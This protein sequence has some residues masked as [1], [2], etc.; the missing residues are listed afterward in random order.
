MNPYLLLGGVL[1]AAVACGVAGFGGYRLGSSVKQGEWDAA[2]VAS[3]EAQDKALKAAAAEIAKIDVKQ[4]TIV[5][6]V[7]R[8]TIEKPVFRDCRSGPDAVR[9]LNAAAGYAEDES[10]D[11]GALSASAPSP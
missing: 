7:T 9:L 10:A 4:Q 3:R 1:A 2:I 11:R 6:K 5:Q 8:E